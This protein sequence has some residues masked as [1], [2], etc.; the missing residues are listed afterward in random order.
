[1]NNARPNTGSLQQHTS[2]VP[3]PHLCSAVGNN[4]SSVLRA[5]LMEMCDHRNGTL[6]KD[7]IIHAFD[8]VENSGN[9]FF[10]YRQGYSHCVSL[11]GSP[12]FIDIDD[13]RVTQFLTRAYCH[14]MVSQVCAKQI[15]ARKG[16]W[17]TAFVDG[18]ADF[19]VN[20]I[21]R[22]LPKRLFAVYQKL[23]THEAGNLTPIKIM[24]SEDMIKAFAKTAQSLAAHH[25]DDPELAKQFET[26][27]N[28]ALCKALKIK[29]PSLAKLNRPT[30]MALLLGLTKPS[31]RNPFRT[32]VISAGERKS[33]LPA[34]G[35]AL[36]CAAAA[37]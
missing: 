23:V 3:G 21:D 8:L 18:F 36:I 31:V 10:L 24:N 12:Q 17:A 25:Q 27:I 30:S 29:G 32:A 6:T 1:M 26:S 16:A 14:D 11:K 4:V 28:L 37:E 5:A 35:D 22:Q 15:T 2:P 20:A 9:L 19:L 7:D 13:R 33:T 34:P